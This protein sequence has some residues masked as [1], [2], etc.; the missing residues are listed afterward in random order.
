MDKSWT[1]K[2]PGQA[3]AVK[4][5]IKSTIRAGMWPRRA[6]ERKEGRRGNFSEVLPVS[7]A[8]FDQYQE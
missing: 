3:R 6:A 4:V 7:V 1:K 5:L 2:I 8:Q